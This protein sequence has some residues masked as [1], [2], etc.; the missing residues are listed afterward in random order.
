M[1]GLFDPDVYLAEAAT[2]VLHSL[3]Y[4]GAA[5]VAIK[6]RQAIVNWIDGLSTHFVGLRAFAV[7]ALFSNIN[8]HVSTEQVELTLFFDKS[9]NPRS[10]RWFLGL[11]EALCKHSSLDRAVTVRHPY[12]SDTPSLLPTVVERISY[13]PREQKLESIADG[14]LVSIKPNDIC[15]LAFA[16]LL[17]DINDAV[18]GE[19]LLKRSILLIKA[20]CCFEAPHMRPDDATGE[21]EHQFI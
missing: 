18:G 9:E 17:E 1:E 21:H 7:G 11:Y 6:R 4:S 13:F 8:P 16:S 3:L 2:L 20:W 15:S 10:D 14:V 5:T 12:N 19:S